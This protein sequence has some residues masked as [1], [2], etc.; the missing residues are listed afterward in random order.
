MLCIPFFLLSFEIHHTVTEAYGIDDS[1]LQLTTGILYL[2]VL[3]HHD[4]TPQLQT[5]YFNTK[6]KRA[7]E[8][9]F[10]F[11]KT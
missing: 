6:T 7:V 10:L 5:Q 11:L 2:L 3:Y 9:D 1:V 8:D 4:F